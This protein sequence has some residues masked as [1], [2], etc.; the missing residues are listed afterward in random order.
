[1]G[2]RGSPLTASIGERETREFGGQ[3]EVR[4]KRVVMVGWHG[5]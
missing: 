3:C 2:E 4:C 1:M 5:G